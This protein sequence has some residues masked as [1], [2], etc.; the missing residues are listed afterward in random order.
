MFACQVPQKVIEHI[1]PP[2]STS[3]TLRKS[4]TMECDDICEMGMQDMIDGAGGEGSVC[5]MELFIKG[6]TADG[7]W[8]K[9][10]PRRDAHNVPPSDCTLSYDINSIILTS[11][12]LKLL[13][14]V[15]IEVLPYS[16]Q[17][18]PI[19]KS[20]HSYVKLL[21]P[22]SEAD[23]E[24]G[25]RSEW[26]SISYSVSSIPH[27]HFAKIGPFKITIHFPCMKHRHPI[28]DRSATLIPWEVQSLFLVEVLY[29]PLWQGR[30]HPQC[31]TRILLWMNGSG[32]HPITPGS[33][34][35]AKQW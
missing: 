25:G 2:P 22:Q 15:E 18:P 23:I 33:Q 29:L 7:C 12:P 10:N 3:I 21:M 13:G 35:Q 1:L 30:T 14:N 6:L 9:F 19:P 26:Y 34:E 4:E 16:G 5:S 20:N 24:A 27:T 8:V 32:R 31:H 28:N 11:D 17:T